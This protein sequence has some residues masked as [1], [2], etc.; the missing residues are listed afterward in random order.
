M[1]FHIKVNRRRFVSRQKKLEQLPDIVRH[2]LWH[3]GVKP[4]SNATFAVSK[5][6]VPVKTGQLKSWI[7]QYL[8]MKRLIGDIYMDR[9]A[10]SKGPVITGKPRKSGK[11]VKYVVNT[12]QK[13]MTVE[14][15]RKKYRPMKGYNYI[16]DAGKAMHAS[17][18]RRI[19]KALKDGLDK[20]QKKVNK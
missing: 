9:K 7:K 8:S 14:F 3:K 10:R 13:F 11:S 18:L 4:S 1:V 6:L 2:H 19:K 17:N 15:G 5:G 12:I 20:A 16:R